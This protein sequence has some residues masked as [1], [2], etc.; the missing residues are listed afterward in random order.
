M[1]VC[2]GIRRMESY[3]LWKRGFLFKFQTDIIIIGEF[4]ANKII[5]YIG[6]LFISSWL[7]GKCNITLLLFCPENWIIAD[8]YEHIFEFQ[9]R[10]LHFSKFASAAGILSYTY[11]LR[12]MCT[13][14]MDEPDKGEFDFSTSEITWLVASSCRCLKSV[15]QLPFFGWRHYKICEMRIEKIWNLVIMSF[16]YLQTI[17]KCLVPRL[18]SEIPKYMV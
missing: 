13:S 2:F 1:G 14:H 17:K 11:F 10:I 3:R 9:G 12:C 15:V 18:P 7:Y 5:P 16:I 4:I 6:L 8:S